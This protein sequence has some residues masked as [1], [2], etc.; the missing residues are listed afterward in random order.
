MEYVGYFGGPAYRIRVE[1]NDHFITRTED[2]GA[3]LTQPLDNPTDVI[4]FR[5]EGLVLLAAAGTEGALPFLS[6][7]EEGPGRIV[8]VSGLFASAGV[9]SLFL[10]QSP[11]GF[12][13]NRVFDPLIRALQWAVYG[14]PRGPYPAP[15]LS[16]AEM[17][18]MIRLDAD[19]SADLDQQIETLDYLDKIA[20]ETGVVALYGWIAADA[21]KAGWDRLAPLAGRLEERGGQIGTHSHHHE[22][23]GTITDEIARIELDSAILEIE[24]GVA[25][26]GHPI[27]TVDYFINPNNTI[28]MVHYGYLADRFT[29]YMTHG[30]ESRAPVAYGNLTWYAGDHHDFVVVNDS[31]VP[32]YQWFYDPEWKYTVDEATAYE[33]ALFDHLFTGIGR[34]VLFNQMWHDYGVNS[35]PIEY[36][37]GFDWWGLFPKRTY[38]PGDLRPHY[39]ALRAKFAAYPVYSPD[40]VDLGQKLRAL[41]QWDLSWKVEGNRLVIDLDLRG[42]PSDS[43]G[44]YVGGMAVRIED[45]PTPVRSVLLNG[46][47]LPAFRDDRVILPDLGPGPNTIEVTFGEEPLPGPRLVYASKRTPSIRR[48]GNRIVVDVKT[49]AKARF[50]FHVDGPFVLMNADEQ[51]WDGEETLHGTASSDRRVVLEET[52]DLG[53]SFLRCT[54]PILGYEKEENALRFTLGAPKGDERTI[55]LETRR[56]V[57]GATFD[58]HD[59][60]LSDRSGPWRL[61]LPEYSRAGTLVVRFG[62]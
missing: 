46:E 19:E 14:D 45:R 20:E 31:P 9:T 3:Y 37:D 7:R 43:L 30:F 24:T 39:D 53:L 54:V 35:A 49:K 6:V 12:Y 52:P 13:P 8:L 47:E 2:T 56:P 48:E 36:G 51:T 44:R 55:V 5:E 38:P 59:L 23:E 1:E 29:F 62:E 18:V 57:R 17:T 22:L 10:N 58:D 61:D 27:G 50:S 11:L 34:G 41:A 33:D 28:P 32:D 21:A 15:Q 4:R 42:A 26:R 16:N 40:A 60:P 25:A